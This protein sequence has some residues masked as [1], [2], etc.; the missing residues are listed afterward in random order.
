MNENE[1]ANAETYLKKHGF[2]CAARGGGFEA[3]CQIMQMWQESH[4]P[5]NAQIEMYHISHQSL[6]LCLS[7]VESK[8]RLYISCSGCARIETFHAHKNDRLHLVKHTPLTTQKYLPLLK[9]YDRKAK[10]A[11]LCDKVCLSL[12]EP[13]LPSLWEKEKL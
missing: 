2:V 3:T 1:I 13:E 6:F 10:F 5:L 11:V 7:N 9:L 4:Q 12:D 8:K